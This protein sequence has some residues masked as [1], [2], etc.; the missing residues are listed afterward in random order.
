M[1]CWSA[2]AL[3]LTSMATSTSRPSVSCS[4]QH[5]VLRRG[6]APGRGGRDRLD[7]NDFARGRTTQQVGDQQTDYALPEHR[8]PL[9][10]TDVRVEH[11]V[12]R[13]LEVG[14]E[15]AFDGIEV[16]RQRDRHTRRDDVARLVRVV[17]EHRLTGAE[18]RL[19][20]GL[21]DAPDARVAVLDREVEA[22]A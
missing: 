4:R 18:R 5:R 19:R 21:D 16:V 11:D 2:A 22:A 6:R 7:G 20:A 17:H 10:E 8:H 14:Q 3:P 13:R 9:A 12:D 1:A 15:H